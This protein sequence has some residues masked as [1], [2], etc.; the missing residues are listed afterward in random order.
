M[1]ITNGSTPFERYELSDQFHLQKADMKKWSVFYSVY[2]NAEYIRFFSG[3]DLPV[4]INIDPFWIYKG[5]TKVGGVVISPNMMRLLFFIPPFQEQSTIVYLLKGIL[6][7][8]SDITLPIHVY[9]VLQDQV[10]LFARLGFS[11]DEHRYRW[12][13][14]PTEPLEHEWNGVSTV[15]QS[16][17]QSTPITRTLTSD[18]E[19][20]H[21]LYRCYSD[22]IQGG[23]S[24][25]KSISHYITET[26]I[27]MKEASEYLLSAS[28]LVYDKRNNAL[29]GT[30]L[31]TMH[32]DV[33]RIQHLG[34]L[35]TYRR[36]GIGTIMIKRS[37]SMLTDLYPSVRVYVMQGNAV[38]SL[39]YNL[40]FMPGPI[41]ISKM[42]VP[43]T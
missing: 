36:R 17:V 31:L 26:Q 8:W 23:I 30:C 12:M 7:K 32:H 29:I 40:G 28:S 37:L 34:I 2:Y 11:P 4:M 39:Y 18:K 3:I 20:G 42:L 9:E 21:L 15:V 16:I 41:E 38:E 1:G 14:R 43:N 10:D 35:P 27:I 5:T 24:K 22:G 13:Q 25:S 6:L 33:P 19:I